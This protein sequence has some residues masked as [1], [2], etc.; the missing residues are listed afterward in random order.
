MTQPNDLYA[1]E[2]MQRLTFAVAYQL[3]VAQAIEQNFDLALLLLL[4]V[5]SGPLPQG[6]PDLRGVLLLL[7]W[8]LLILAID[9]GPMNDMI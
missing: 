9:D 8:L 5:L 2:K 6:L 3:L 1:D 4:R 7:G